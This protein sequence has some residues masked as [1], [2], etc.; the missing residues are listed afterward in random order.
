MFDV[1]LSHDTKFKL[2]TVYSNFMLIANHKTR[3]K[4]IKI[5]PS[6]ED[7]EAQGKKQH[8]ITPDVVAFIN[9]KC[10]KRL[11]WGARQAIPTTVPF[12]TS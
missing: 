4:E 3:S 8:I 10:S 11:A 7:L 6:L 12:S 2:V 9:K 5:K 1:T